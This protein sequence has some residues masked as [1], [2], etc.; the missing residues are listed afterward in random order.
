MV[1][2]NADH[3]RDEGHGVV[4]AVEHRDAA[5]IFGIEQDLPVGFLAYSGARSVRNVTDVLPQ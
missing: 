1:G 5:F 2:V 4:D 3:A